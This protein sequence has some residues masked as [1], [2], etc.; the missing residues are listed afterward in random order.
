MTVSQLGNISGSEEA[1]SFIVTN[2]YGSLKEARYNVVIY[3][4]GTEEAVRSEHT[5][6]IATEGRDR[7]RLVFYKEEVADAKAL[8]GNDAA[9]WNPPRDR[10][11]GYK[12][13]STLWGQILEISVKP[14]YKFFEEFAK[15]VK[16]V[17]TD[18]KMEHKT[19]EENKGGQ[20]DK[21]NP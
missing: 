12:P 4:L 3:H 1:Y 8:V 2:A 21:V 6:T 5:Y 18:I 11:S 20:G 7:M 13:P 14:G 15:G 19:N 10:G 16:D 9:G 17:I